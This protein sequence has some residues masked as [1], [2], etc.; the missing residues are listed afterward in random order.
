VQQQIKVS[1]ATK[2][3]SLNGH[4]HR[5]N[6][7]INGTKRISQNYSLSAN[8]MS[9]CPFTFYKKYIF[10]EKKISNH[11]VNSMQVS[12]GILSMNVSKITL[13]NKRQQ[14]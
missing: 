8:V 5:N 2:T 3:S 9:L 14:I 1:F 4:F 7:G 13:A 11:F 10:H 12:L 6:F